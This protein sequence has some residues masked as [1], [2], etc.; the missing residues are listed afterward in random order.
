MIEQRAMV[1][2]KFA[3]LIFAFYEYSKVEALYPPCEDIY[4]IYTFYITDD[5]KS[6]PTKNRVTY[7]NINL[8]MVTQ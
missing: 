7:S 1:Y 8:H 5:A 3:T 6:V 2:I 4:K